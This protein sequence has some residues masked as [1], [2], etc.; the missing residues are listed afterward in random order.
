MEDKYSSIAE[1]VRLRRAKLIPAIGFIL[2]VSV[3]FSC[4]GASQTTNSS[5]MSNQAAENE[6]ATS[7]LSDTPVF[8]NKQ[9]E[10]VIIFPHLVSE[11]DLQKLG[12]DTELIAAKIYIE[13]GVGTIGL[14]DGKVK[15]LKKETQD[16]LNYI[17]KSTETRNADILKEN[18]SKLTA[19]AYQSDPMI[20][21][22]IA[23]S[24]ESE[25][26]VRNLRAY[27]SEQSIYF[28]V[29]IKTD[30]DSLNKIASEF[31]N[32]KYSL[33]RN[34]IPTPQYVTNRQLDFQKASVKFKA[35]DYDASALTLN[36]SIYNYFSKTASEKYGVQVGDSK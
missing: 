9:N 23:E 22:M 11:A 6:I 2:L 1:V 28:A 20:R 12:S 14:R 15:E 4:N 10:A 33:N 27:N 35:R 32:A 17:I 7:K 34:F 25:E 36:D 31:P 16:T 21:A 3:L 29:I 19:Q 5:A 30:E 8:S 18:G 24:V 13:G 26:R